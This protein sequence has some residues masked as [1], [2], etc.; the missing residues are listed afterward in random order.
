MIYCNCSECNYEDALGYKK[1]MPIRG[2]PGVAIH[3]CDYSR[4]RGELANEAEKY[5]LENTPVV[6]PDAGDDV[7]AA[8]D[9]VYM[10]LFTSK[11]EQLVKEA[12]L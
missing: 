6:S 11:M 9:K 3:D 2:V 1:S 12:R 8:M 4:R 10:K 7:K 5:A